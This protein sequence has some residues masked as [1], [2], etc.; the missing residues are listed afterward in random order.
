MKN[1]LMITVACIWYI[2]IS[3]WFHPNAED[4]V[5][6]DQVQ[7]KV[8]E[9]WR[10]NSERL[11]D[12]WEKLF[13]TL[14]NPTNRFDS[15]TYHILS[16]IET[17][18]IEQLEVRWLESWSTLDPEIF[19][20]LSKVFGVIV[21]DIRATDQLTQVWVLEHMDLHEDYFD[22]QTF[23]DIN[24]FNKDDVYL[25]YCSSMKMSNIF[26]KQLLDK[27]IMNAHHLDGWIQNR[28]D[29]WYPIVKI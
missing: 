9:M 4:R 2:S 1:L 19:D 21:L 28:I 12:I 27:W 17:Y 29:E 20:R 16:T 23:E 14:E 13:E 7:V 11:E 6:L 24:S 18:I 22:P 15:R 10:D 25:I 26:L 3:F 5:L 8:F